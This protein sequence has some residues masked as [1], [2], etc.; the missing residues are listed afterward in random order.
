MRWWCA[1]AAALILGAHPAVAVIG[2]PVLQC[3]DH[4]TAPIDNTDHCLLNSGSSINPANFNCLVTAVA[5]DLGN[6]VTGISMDGGFTCATSGTIDSANF[7]ALNRRNSFVY[8][9]PST[10]VPSNN[11]VTFTVTFNGNVTNRDISVFSITNFQNVID[12]TAKTGNNTSTSMTTASIT[13]TNADDLI[14]AMWNF[15]NTGACGVSSSISAPWTRIG[16]DQCASNG[17]TFRT[18]AVQYRAVGIGTFSPAATLSS[19]K[20]WIGLAIALE[21]VPATPTPTPTNTNT[22]TQTFTNT[23]TPTKTPTNTPT[24]PTAT[25][26]PTNTPTPTVT[27]TPTLDH[28]IGIGGEWNGVSEMTAATGVG[29]NCGRATS[30]C[31][32]G[33]GCYLDSPGSI[34]SFQQT[35]APPQ[36]ELRVQTCFRVGDLT[37]CTGTGCILRGTNQTSNGKGSN[38]RIQDDGKIRLYPNG[39]L[40]P[41]AV[42]G[43]VLTTGQYYCARHQTIS[44]P[45]GTITLQLVDSNCRSLGTDIGCSGFDTGSG[46]LDQDVLGDAV[47]SA[48]TTI[49]FDDW[50]IHTGVS[51]PQ[52]EA[53]VPQ[54][55]TSV[56]SGSCVN[57][58]STGSTDCSSNFA[59]CLTTLPTV[60]DPVLTHASAPLDVCEMYVT[61]AASTTPVLTNVKKV[62][63][64]RVAFN[65]KSSGG[66]FQL[67]TVMNT[68][69]QGFV[70]V[71]TVYGDWFVSYLT[72]PG[73]TTP[74]G[75]AVPTSAGLKNTDGNTDNVDGL[76]VLV[77]A[78]M[79]T[80]TT[81]FTPSLTNTPTVT[82]T[83][84]ITQTPTVTPTP[85][86]TPTG[87]LPPSS[88]PTNTPSSTPTVTFTPTQTPTITPSPCPIVGLGAD[89]LKICLY[90][91]ASANC[92]S[93]AEIDVRYIPNKNW[94]CA[95]GEFDNALHCLQDIPPNPYSVVQQYPVPA[96][97]QPIFRFF[98][99]VPTNCPSSEQI[100]IRADGNICFN[101]SGVTV[102]NSAFINA[103]RTACFDPDALTY[104]AY[105]WPWNNYGGTGVAFD[106]SNQDLYI[107]GYTVGSQNRAIGYLHY[108]DFGPGE[109]PTDYDY[110]SPLPKAASFFSTVSTTAQ[111]SHL[112]QDKTGRIDFGDY[113]GNRLGLINN[114]AF[115]PDTLPLPGIPPIYNAGFGYKPWGQLVEGTNPGRLWTITESYAHIFR[116]DLSSCCSLTSWDLTQFNADAGSNLALDA[117]GSVWFGI[118][119]IGGNPDSSQWDS[120]LGR[121]RAD[122]V[123]EVTTCWLRSLLNLNG[124]I[125]GITVDP[126]TGDIYFTV[127]RSQQL[128]WVHRL[129]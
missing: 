57:W 74:W 45:S 49:N 84:T 86:E 51:F 12:G 91:V 54:F 117:E 28:V 62:D 60:G 17:G 116:W 58:S 112:I 101:Q 61:T 128:G 63:E 50:V 129:P 98:P 35:I 73:T 120:K 26:T 77:D 5:Y 41:C 27:P 64:V 69:I 36:G 82:N 96:P 15:G 42:H 109:T 10:T 127:F 16:T 29:G 46:A 99:D 70:S 11:S 48:L 79:P 93:H 81:T 110:R 125:N 123:V 102:N 87:T 6:T 38:L 121:V 80:A 72:Q 76:R 95:V 103:T 1:I 32:T 40:F 78:Q 107:G 18:L 33:A 43:S 7:Q 88:T 71:T 122:G 114:R 47:N 59:T 67:A 92:G 3:E 94:V 124:G 106:E 119:N 19:S 75:Q 83:P 65:A 115:V 90:D 9:C 118:A 108:P 4:L 89:T 66:T 100:A 8:C 53:V 21:G 68:I 23:S 30:N 39:A 105:D 55:T 97:T 13:T 2:T 22:P 104:V 113:T 52:C 20:D 111:V 37:P 85:T 126:N 31:R 56:L 34:C 25:P 14:L 44:G 24:Q